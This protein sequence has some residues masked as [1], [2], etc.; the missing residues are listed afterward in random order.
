MI[1]NLTEA[2]WWDKNICDEMSIDEFTQYSKE[3]TKLLDTKKK[4]WDNSKI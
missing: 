4:W 1:L 3:L 2:L